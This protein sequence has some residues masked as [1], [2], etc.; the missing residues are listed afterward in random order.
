MALSHIKSN[1]NNWT[2]SLGGQPFIFDH[3]HP[4]YNGLCE[5]VMASDEDEFVSFLILAQLSRTGQKATLSSVTGSCTTRT[6][7]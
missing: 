5:C 7:R 6:S 2:V 4:E 3:T 1:D